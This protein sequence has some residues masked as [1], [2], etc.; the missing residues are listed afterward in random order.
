MEEQMPAAG[1]VHEHPLHGAG[2]ETEIEKT[3]TGDFHGLA[4]FGHVEPRGDVGG[5]LARIYASGFRQSH[6]G[7]ALVIP[8]FWIR[9]RPDLHGRGVRIG[10]HL[11]DGGMQVLF[12][13]VM[14]HVTLRG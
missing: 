14:Q 7:V 9:T 4:P 13:Q 8:E 10:Q 6:Q 3:G 1:G 2:F 12:D 5:E 11:E